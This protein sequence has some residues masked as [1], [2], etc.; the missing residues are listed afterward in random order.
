MT[1]E[2]QGGLI[3]GQRGGLI[4]GWE[5]GLIGSGMVNCLIAL[6]HISTSGYIAP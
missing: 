6:P 2:Q 4:D 3:G 1:S 5:G